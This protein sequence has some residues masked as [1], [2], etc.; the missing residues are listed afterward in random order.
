MINKTPSSQSPGE[1]NQGGPVRS[2]NGTS[3]QESEV[4]LS[5]LIDSAMDGIVVLDA[6]QRIVSFNSAAEIIFRCSASDVLGHSIN[7]FIP[8]TFRKF[9]AEFIRI[10]AEENNTRRSMGALNEAHTVGLRA[11]GE[12]FPTEISI[13]QFE[14][15]GKKFFAAIVRDVSERQQVE[16]ALRESEAR[17]RTLAE[18][19]HDMIWI[20]NRQGEIEYVN[21]H[22]AQQFGTTPE[23]LV[24]KR[25]ADLFPKDIAKRQMLNIKKVMT[26]GEPAYVEAPN[27]FPDRMTWLGTSL[28]P[29]RNE[30]GEIYA[31]L[32]VA[33]DITARK[34]AEQALQRHDAILE[35]V[36]FA[37]ENFLKAAKWQENIEDVLAHLGLAAQASRAYIFENTYDQNGSV[38]SSQRFEWTSPGVTPQIKNRDL[39]NVALGHIDSGRWLK[40]LSEN[41]PLY[42]DVENASKSQ[43]ALLDAQGILSIVVVPIFSGPTFWGFMGYDECRVRREWTPMEIQALKTAADILGAAIQREQAEEILRLSE[44]EYRSLFEN[45]LEGIYRTSPEGKILTANPALIKMLGLDSMDDLLLLD[46]SRD[47]YLRPENRNVVRRALAEADEQRNVELHL[48]RRDGQP[49]IVLNN[50]RTIRDAKGKVLY[51]EG[52]MVDITDRKQAVEQV[53]RR[54]AELE[55]LYESGLAL[56]QS[57]DPQAIAEKVIIVLSDRLNWDHAAVRLRAEAGDGVELLAFSGSR[58]ENIASGTTHARAAIT[59]VGQGLSGWVIEHGKPVR[60]GN[61]DKDKRYIHT[62]PKMRSGM[63]IPMK[64]GERTIGCISVESPELNAF[65]EFDER[66][67]ATL[68][69]Q[70]AIAIENARLFAQTTQRLEQVSVLHQIDMVISSS[71]ELRT[72]LEFVLGHVLTQLSV[73]AAGVLLLDSATMTLKFAHGAG[74]RSAKLAGFSLRL[75]ESQAGHSALER[76]PIFIPDLVKSGQGFSHPELLAEEDFK[77]YACMPLIAKG[78]VMGVLEIFNRTTLV[79][80][81]EWME[82]FNV[83]AGQTAIAIDNR[84]MFDDLQR[85]HLELSLAYDATI[86]GWSHALDLRDRETEGH[87][88][89]VTD[90]TIRL[91]RS[92]GLSDLEIVHI[93]RGGLLH[94][95]GKMGVPD[96]ILNK[97]GPLTE[98]ELR[99]MRMHPQYAYDMLMP[100]TYLRPALDIP[101]AHHEKWDGS[102]Y[103]RGLKGYAIPVAARIFAVSDVFDAL[104]SDRPYRKAWSKEKTFEY[105]RSQAGRHFAPEIVEAFLSIVDAS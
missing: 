89:R 41:Q 28:A 6:R 70:A 51:Y 64:I 58:S 56:S 74:F 25:V 33:R 8:R 11:D 87:T 73:D 98:D 23:K 85:S 82:F 92:L 63:Y 10:F 79:P 66:L 102:G 43:K 86:E 103:P 9:H 16:K 50:S 40:L 84:I 95:I 94:D 44:T 3:P 54:V 100:I 27:T 83:L 20:I 72:I 1:N 96:T 48:E 5:A 68:S 99:V 78:E 37:A 12:E 76:E 61:L 46:F 30:F 52:T 4:W 36:S 32:G 60:T 65:N 93:R 49:L 57:L 35:A 104:T 2:R 55:A 34:E 18:A 42:G 17:Y 59:R 29:L 75:G 13:S 53:N 26:S 90:L 81:D 62:L 15:G 24:G 14:S 101:Y 47:L 45:A 22:A 21:L 19:A 77:A 97:P 31:V 71:A 7:R 67:M 39:Q 80:D 38:L 88:R 105:L 91:A 69:A